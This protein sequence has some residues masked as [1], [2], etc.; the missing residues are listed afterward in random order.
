[1]I[2]SDMPEKVE[3]PTYGTY[4]HF[5]G[6]RYQVLGVAQDADGPGRLV[7][8]CVAGSTGKLWYRSLSRW[9]DLVLPEGQTTKVPRFQRESEAAV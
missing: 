7:I 6:G 1:M 5:K 9:C 8:Y 3:E 4:R 2:C